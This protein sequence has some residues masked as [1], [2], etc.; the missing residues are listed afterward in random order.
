MYPI[1]GFKQINVLITFGYAVCIFL[2]K[3]F[4]FTLCPQETI[5]NWRGESGK[6]LTS[7]LQKRVKNESMT[8]MLFI[9]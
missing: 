5:D 7:I 6:P 9:T 2:I 4:I 3:N 1:K 8:D